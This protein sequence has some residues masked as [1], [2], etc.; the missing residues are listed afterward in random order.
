M[1]P[2][3]SDPAGPRAAADPLAALPGGGPAAAELAARLRDHLAGGRFQLTTHWHY[4]TSLCYFQLP[5]DLARMD[6]VIVKG[7]ANY[8]RL[9]GDA[10]WPPTTPFAQA[11]AYF[12]A[13]L[14]ALRTLKGE[15]IVDLQEGEAGRLS[16]TDP[17]WLVNGQRG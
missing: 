14:V 17:A 6:R 8:R 9:L 2:P 15:I 5:A 13:A 7:D 10:H 1:K 3:P 4:A 16:A 11:T 12:P